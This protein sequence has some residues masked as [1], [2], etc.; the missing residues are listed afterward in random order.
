MNLR[1]AKRALNDGFIT[2]SVNYNT[3]FESQHECLMETNRSARAKLLVNYIV[4]VKWKQFL[5]YHFINMFNIYS[6]T[7]TILLSLIMEYH[8]GSNIISKLHFNFAIVFNI[9]RLCILTSINTRKC[10]N[11]LWLP[12]ITG[13]QLLAIVINLPKCKNVSFN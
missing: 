10:V 8:G 13:A 11:F 7:I 4:Y 6:I 3:K 1:C 9:L 12:Q 2:Y 5:L